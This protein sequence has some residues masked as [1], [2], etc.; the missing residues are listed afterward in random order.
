VQELIGLEP[1]GRKPWIK[2]HLEV[3]GLH[4]TESGNNAPGDGAHASVS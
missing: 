4:E 1:A 2:P 3:A